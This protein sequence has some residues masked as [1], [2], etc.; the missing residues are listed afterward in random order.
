MDALSAFHLLRPLWLLA[1]PLWLWLAFSIWR[2]GR[3]GDGWASVCDPALLTYLTGEHESGRQHHSKLALAALMVAGLLTLIALAGPVWQQLPQPVYR[4]QSALVIGLDLSRSMLA[5]DL[6]PDRLTRAKQKVQDILA[7]RK[8]GQTALVVFAGAAFDVVPLT[9][10]SAAILT[11]LDSLTPDMM[12][13]QGSRASTAIEHAGAIFKRGAI[14]Y[15]TLLLLTDGVDQEAMESAETLVRKGHR[16]SVI[17]VGSEQGA[18]IPAADE[19]GGFVK[20]G[21]GNIVIP[22]L[23]RVMLQA[24][25]DAGHGVYRP[26]R[27]DNGDIDDIPGLEPSVTDRIIKQ[28]QL[29]SDLWREE[30]P[31]LLLI[32]LPILSLAFRRGVLL[33]I[34]LLPMVMM[35]DQ[36]QAM[37]WQDLWQT[38]DQQGQ[39]LMRKQSPE[40]AAALFTDP[41]W[42]GAALYRAGKY[43]ESAAALQAATTADGSYNRG[44]ALAKA[45]DLKGALDAYERA[46]KLDPAHKDAA[47][48]R[49]LVK[50][51]LKQS[52]KQQSDQQKPSDKQRNDDQQQ[53]SQGKQGGENRN[54]GSSGALPKRSQTADQ[55]NSGRKQQRQTGTGTNSEQK[56]QRRDSDE[57]SEQQRQEKQQSGQQAG[58]KQASDH[59]QQGSRQ[60][61][62]ASRSTPEQQEKAAAMQQWLRRIPDDPGGLLR[63]KFRYQYQQQQ[64]S[65]GSA[66]RAW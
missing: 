13:V 33:S 16:V 66:G 59:Q 6:K 31:W 7:L 11:L 44:N 52:S 64:H 57:A 17:G 10:D 40:A 26:L 22:H 23:D 1:I 56:K 32:V 34:L 25:A 5:G 19:Q 50:Q 29:Q 18:P 55:D 38:P 27:F 54:Q 14:K 62:A 41:E 8:E 53:S 46:L 20:D 58:A 2:R 49:D 65:N 60:A 39:T 63:R 51:A 35:P 24:L 12:P 42:R 48:N 36:A 4:A 61:T 28:E 15:G 9:S 3:S 30:G 21:S 43:S 45:G 37:A 47:F